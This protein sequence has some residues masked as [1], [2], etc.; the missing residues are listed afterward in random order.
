MSRNLARWKAMRYGDVLLSL[1][2]SLRPRRFGGTRRCTP[3]RE[4]GSNVADPF[5]PDQGFGCQ[6]G[7]T[8]KMIAWGLHDW[9][10][11]H[12][13]VPMVAIS[14]DKLVEFTCRTWDCLSSSGETTFVTPFK[15]TFGV[16]GAG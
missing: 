6:L 11:R 3:L 14:I 13:D 1:T 12:G 2:A 5:S 4:G 10:C 15:S 16:H 9:A 8:L 7:K